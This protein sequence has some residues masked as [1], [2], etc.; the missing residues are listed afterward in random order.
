MK[1]IAAIP[2][3]WNQTLPI[4]VKVGEHIVMAREKDGICMWGLTDWKER[5]VE[6]D[7]S[8]LGDGEFNAEI[9][10]DGIKCR[11]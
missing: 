6:V 9:F 2:T 5:D 1:F 4:S 7:L 11:S 3:V 8:F 10:R